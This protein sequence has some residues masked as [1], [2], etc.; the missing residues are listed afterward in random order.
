MPL[1]LPMRYGDQPP[2]PDI[3]VLPMGDCPVAPSTPPAC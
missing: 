2:Y 1:L 3:G